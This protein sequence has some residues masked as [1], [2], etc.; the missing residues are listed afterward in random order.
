MR[1][2]TARI[3]ARVQL[4][5]EILDLLRRVR[6]RRLRAEKSDGELHLRRAEAGRH[7]G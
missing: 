4:F 6:R 3:N 7:G 2:N 5:I 1:Y